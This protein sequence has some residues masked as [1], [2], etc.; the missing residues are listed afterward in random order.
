MTESIPP[1]PV[2]CKPLLLDLLEA[3]IVLAG[4][5]GQKLVQVHL[6]L[7]LLFLLLHRGDA[8]PA[9][10]V[11]SRRIPEAGLGGPARVGVAQRLLRRLEC[12]GA[13]QAAG[14]RPN[15]AVFLLII[16]RNVRF[17]SR[18]HHKIAEAGIL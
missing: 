8:L 6:L 1:L 17:S 2:T 9:H 3:L 4:V 10:R 5:V 7:L 14:P 12:S 15:S 16:I 18:T 11:L 13:G